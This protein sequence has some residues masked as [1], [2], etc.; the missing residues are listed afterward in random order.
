MLRE[1]LSG[2]LDAECRVLIADDPFSVVVM[3]PIMSRAHELPES[4]RVC[5][6]DSSTSS[7]SCGGG[8]QN[9]SVTFLLTPCAAGTVPLAVVV[10]SSQAEDDYACGFRRLRES[11]LA[12]FGGNSYPLVFVTDDSAAIRNALRKVWPESQRWIC[13]LLMALA[14]WRWLWD[15]D[16]LI[17]VY[18]RPVLMAEFRSLMT[19]ATPEL[20]EASYYAAMSSSVGRKYPQWCSRVRAYWER[21]DDW[22]AAWR[23]RGY[24]L[25]RFSEVSV[26][27]FRDNVLSQAK[28]YNPVALVEYVCTTM[29]QFCSRR[30]LDFSNS[31]LSMP[32]RWLGRLLEKSEH[33][34]VE[35]LIQASESVFGV[36]SASDASTT[37]CVDV[38]CEL[39]SC[40]EGVCG[41]YCEHLAVVLHLRTGLTVRFAISRLFVIVEL[42]D[43][44]FAALKI[45]DS[46]S[47]GNRR[48]ENITSISVV[49]KSIGLCFI[50]YRCC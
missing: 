10:T 13:P 11:G 17:A 39:C 40:R 47:I 22:C 49:I 1:K 3:T 41:R 9:T 30:L 45:Y 46:V 16:N 33:V 42:I 8:L 36:P 24:Q 14:N 4:G 29:E 26:R 18:D 27:L 19:S 28:A 34:S 25:S 20:A 2:Y 35:S 44:T 21:K 48:T 7:T 15:V 38:L 37:H 43:E 50:T 31:L 12:S 32:I 6:V 23:P 5:F